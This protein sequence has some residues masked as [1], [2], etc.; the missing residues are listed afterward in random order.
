MARKKSLGFSRF[1]FYWVIS[2]IGVI[3][4]IGIH[5]Y[6]KLGE[7]V[8][9]F[10]FEVLAQNFSAAVYNHRSRWI[11]AQQRDNYLLRIDKSLVQFS[12]QGWPLAVLNNEPAYTRV[13]LSS[14]LSLWKGFLQNPPAISIDGSDA[15]GSRAYHLSLKTENLCHFEW[16]QDSSGGFYFEYS[17]VSGGVSIHTSPNVKN[18]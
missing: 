8:Q 6:S 3:A 11:L 5:R 17:P 15:Y 16:M 1:E 18:S 13:T 4:V 10:G 9:R 12:L 7:E 14:C 2:V